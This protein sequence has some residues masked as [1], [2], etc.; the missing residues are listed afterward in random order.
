MA[1]R[2]PLH[3][4]ETEGGVVVATHVEIATT[5]LARGLGLMFRQNL[6]DGHGLAIVP[7]GSIHMFCMKFP[8][9]VAFVDD[10]GRVL[11]ALHGIKPWR[12]T[13]PVRGAKAAIE[14]P[15]GTLKV[16]GVEKGSVL[17]L[18]RDE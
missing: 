2:L 6:P 5:F 17:N 13:W 16:H 4:L 7:C 3:R 10:K 15:A 9:D 14:L 11:R 1:S 8:L 12:A 18:V